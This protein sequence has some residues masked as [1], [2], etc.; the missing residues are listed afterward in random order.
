MSLIKRS[1]V[2]Y[3][4]TTKGVFTI[5]RL[6]E[7]VGAKLVLNE[8]NRTPLWMG[9]KLGDCEQQH[10][11]ITKQ[12]SEFH[13]VCDLNFHDSI[14]VILLDADDNIYAYGGVREKVSVALIKD[15]ITKTAS[16]PLE[17]S[18]EALQASSDN[19]DI[20]E[21][22]SARIKVAQATDSN[23]ISPSTETVAAKEIDAESI[24]MMT[25]DT[26]SQTES[27]SA[28]ETVIT[29]S[30]KSSTVVEEQK[31]MEPQAESVQMDESEVLAE[32]KPA[33]APPPSNPEPKDK[34][35][36][37]KVNEQPSKVYQQERT[38]AAQSDPEKYN[39]AQPQWM[40]ESEKKTAANPFNIPK[41]KN[42]YQAVRSRLEEIMT[43][44]PK[45]AE[46]EKLIP[47]SEWV[48]VKY[49]GEDY[50]VVGR[51]YE[52]NVVTYIGYG[53]P[54][55]ENV[56]PPREAE[57]LCDFL[58][59]PNKQGVGYWLMFQK[60]DDGTISREL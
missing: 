44:N 25:D 48:K 24:V 4:D 45:E 15:A 42:F 27:T 50:Y 54:G 55:V 46:L 8:P 1:I 16:V 10:Y 9:I 22:E 38:Q 58:P 33:H 37:A 7:T 17:Q 53:V 6:G 59:L 28:N 30:A 12:I 14:G 60:A 34:G 29:A 36:A 3:K 39:A 35:Q 2:I 47:D 32:P 49:D 18:A 52:N 41:A 57:E 21:S 31:I 5:I 11:K 40:P 51:L 23:S 56:R 26:E 43:I 20:E 13:L 19:C